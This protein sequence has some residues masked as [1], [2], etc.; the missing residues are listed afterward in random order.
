MKND[1]DSLNAVFDTSAFLTNFLAR[2]AN[3]EAH[4][5]R[6][7][8]SDS[9]HLERCIVDV[10][11]AIL[12]FSATVKADLERNIIKR[13]VDTFLPVAQ[14]PLQKLKDEVIQR[15]ATAKE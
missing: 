15:E 3:I 12:E 14:Q 7:S 8:F 1:Q 4:Y 13:T 5:L 9:V 6:K 10:Y 11:F 2:Y